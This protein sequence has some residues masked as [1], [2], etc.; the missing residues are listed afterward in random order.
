[1][2]TLYN[3]KL[4]FRKKNSQLNNPENN[5][6]H[7]NLASDKIIKII[8][9]SRNNTEMKKKFNTLSQSTHTIITNKV[10]LGIKDKIKSN[11]N[12]L[13]N[14][15]KKIKLSKLDGNNLLQLIKGIYLNEGENE[16]REII[17]NIN[18]ILRNKI[19]EQNLEEEKKAIEREENF[20]NT[21]K[22]SQPL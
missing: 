13:Y 7:N 2:S 14:I 19:K 1:M 4:I 11:P 3:P 10:I 21:G 8:L 18:N 12:I 20:P 15:I 17:T 22:F 9:E 16:K 6:P 5:L